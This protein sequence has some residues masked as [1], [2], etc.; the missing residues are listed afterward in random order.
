MWTIF[1]RTGEDR[2]YVE[3][4]KRYWAMSYVGDADYVPSGLIKRTMLEKE[5]DRKESSYY[6]I[7]A[8][9]PV[10]L[11]SNFAVHR[12]SSPLGPRRKPVHSDF[13]QLLGGGRTGRLNTSSTFF[14]RPSTAG[15]RKRNFTESSSSVTSHSADSKSNPESDLKS[16]P[17]SEEEASLEAEAEGS[18]DA[19][20]SGTEKAED[21][22]GTETVP[23]AEEAEELNE[24]LSTSR[25]SDLA[26]VDNSVLDI[27]IGAQVELQNLV[28]KIE[29]NRETGEV[30]EVH[31][32]QR[33]YVVMLNSSGAMKK[34][35]A[36]KVVLLSS[37]K[38]RLENVPED[39]KDDAASMR[40][41][42]EGTEHL[43][44]S[45]QMTVSHV[46]GTF[47]ETDKYPARKLNREDFHA[48]LPPKATAERFIGLLKMHVGEDEVAE[49]VT[50]LAEEVAEEVLVEE[51][52]ASFE[53]E[54]TAPVGKAV[55]EV[56]G[57]P[58][59]VRNEEVV[60]EDTDLDTSKFA[61]SPVKSPTSTTENIAPVTETTKITVLAAGTT[62][63]TVST[64]KAVEQEA[65]NTSQPQSPKSGTVES[66]TSSSSDTSS[67]DSSSSSTESISSA[68]TTPEEKELEA[69]TL[70]AEAVL[71]R[72]K[73][74]QKLLREKRPKST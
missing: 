57:S 41:F 16:D 37:N 22:M 19:R 65:I 9:L 50:V 18:E 67:K 31:Q 52:F 56:A 34:V 2:K 68:S 27:P 74:Q 69:E 13:E 4:Q 62:K 43:K 26:E 48:K 8:P 70:K 14:N 24:K 17:E 45:D 55:E 40:E 30:V 47:N 53:E 61:L 28:K 42:A 29:L 10:E 23:A 32:D 49:G 73:T 72:L 58:K 11:A 12:D 36:E 25:T 1:I 6:K 46:E 7:S 54:E 38:V 71:Q 33:R 20:S 59:A 39:L 63:S 60:P 15:T 35:N 44:S 66:R 5:W 51:E 3:E 64:T 21:K